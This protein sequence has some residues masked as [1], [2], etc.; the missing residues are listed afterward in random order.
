M[1]LVNYNCRKKNKAYQKCIRKWYSTE[2]LPGKSVSQEDACGDKFEAYREC[3]LTG[4]KQ[5]IWE[6]KGL[7]PPKDGS[8]LADF[9]E[10]T[11]DEE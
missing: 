1:D 2:F 9:M 7:P 8:L 11:K 4:V 3:I 10:T 6:K 5:E